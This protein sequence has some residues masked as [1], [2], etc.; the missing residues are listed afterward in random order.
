M[1]PNF[2]GS[3]YYLGAVVNGAHHIPFFLHYVKIFKYYWSLVYRLNKIFFLNP[4]QTFV[5]SKTRRGGESPPPSQVYWGPWLFR[6]NLHDCIT[7]AILTEPNQKNYTFTFVCICFHLWFCL[8]V[9]KLA[10]IL[11]V[12]SQN[13]T[14]ESCLICVKSE[15]YCKSSIRS[16]LCV[17]LDW[18]FPRLVFKV[19]QEI[20]IL[21]QMFF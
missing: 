15:K 6:V 13:V 11:A 20:C 5:R 10:L 12:V 17:I 3:G 14:N 19:I 1:N 8:C 4:Y 18:D 16:R 2:W 7:I 21:E 9:Q